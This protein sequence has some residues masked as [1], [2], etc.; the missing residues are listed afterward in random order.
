MHL[1][2]KLSRMFEQLI[3]KEENSAERVLKE[4]LGRDIARIMKKI[5]VPK[6]KDGTMFGHYSGGYE[7]SGSEN[8]GVYSIGF[9]KFKQNELQKVLKLAKSE[10]EKIPGWRVVVYHSHIEMF[11]EQKES[12]TKKEGMTPEFKKA[13]EITNAFNNKRTGVEIYDI[14]EDPMVYGINLSSRGAEKID[15][16]QQRI[17]N[18]QEAIKICEALNRQKIKSYEN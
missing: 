16:I 1:N 12:L 6:S 13:K 4:S 14:A 10:L 2:K 17:K 3:S 9:Y 11:K 15:A 7:L 8:Q 5:G 18:I